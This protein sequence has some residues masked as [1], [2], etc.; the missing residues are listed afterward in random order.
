MNA[1]K[2]KIQGN[3]KF[4]IS[5]IDNGVVR[6][7]ADNVNGNRLYYQAMKQFEFDNTKYKHITSA[8]ILSDLYLE[9]NY[10]DM[11]YYASNSFMDLVE[12]VPFNILFGIINK[13]LLFIDTNLIE[14]E[15]TMDFSNKI[16]EKYHTIKSKMQYIDFDNMG[17][18]RIF[19]DMPAVILP[20]GYNHGDLTFSN[21]LFTKESNE[22]ILIDFLDSFIDTPL[23]DI[24]KLRQDTYHKWLLQTIKYKV[25]N[26]RLLLVLDK[27]D[28]LIDK[29]YR[30][31]HFYVQHYHMLSVLNLLRILPY[32]VNDNVTNYLIE[33]ITK[34]CKKQV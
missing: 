32:A 30:S 9:M 4:S 34:L 7:Y 22:I 26:T 2:F 24:V 14:S 23:L 15:G 21:M 12:V 19:E 3:S 17:C 1:P 18:D 16:M 10:F 28:T 31:N 33:N 5:I 29:H 13:M 11:Q 27:L 20:I 25:D 6:K 8:K